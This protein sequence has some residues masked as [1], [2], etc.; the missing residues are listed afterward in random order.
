M[1][2]GRRSILSLFKSICDYYCRIQVLKRVKELQRRKFM[3]LEKAHI[4][5]IFSLHVY[6]H[7]Y[8][9]AS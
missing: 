2:I 9:V 1:G 6:T 4:L 7:L 8:V 5:S 3:S